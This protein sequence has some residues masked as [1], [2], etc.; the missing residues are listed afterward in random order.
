M[1]YTATVT[2]SNCNEVVTLLDMKGCKIV[3][4]SPDR[5]NGVIPH[6]DITLDMLPL[7]NSLK[8]HIKNAPRVIVYCPSLNIC[9]DLYATFHFELAR[10]RFLLST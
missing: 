1:A 2:K 6:M 10:T 9:A 3:S 4:T 5:P 8:E 7:L